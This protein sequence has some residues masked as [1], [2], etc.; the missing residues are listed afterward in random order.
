MSFIEYLKVSVYGYIGLDAA[1]CA[2]LV[3]SIAARIVLVG[4]ALISVYI[5]GKKVDKWVGK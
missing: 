1:I 2:T 4:V 5:Y 3:H